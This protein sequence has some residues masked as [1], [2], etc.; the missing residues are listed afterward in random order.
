MRTAG[1]VSAVGMELAGGV[2]VCL[3]AGYWADGKLGTA[4]YLTVAG[5]ALGTAVGFKAVYRA[6][7]Q[8]QRDAE[9]QARRE[10]DDEG[11]DRGVSDLGILGRTTLDLPAAPT[12]RT[13]GPGTGRAPGEARSTPTSEER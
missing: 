13:E 5:M 12:A 11:G 10:R 7:K 1:R 8:M 2:I 4:P 3:I 9:E 6:A